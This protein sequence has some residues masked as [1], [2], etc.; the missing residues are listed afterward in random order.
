[1]AGRKARAPR[2]TPEAG[3][4]DV[5]DV[6]VLPTLRAG[7]PQHVPAPLRTFRRLRAA[8]VPRD[9]IV[10]LSCRIPAGRTLEGDNAPLL[11]DGLLPR[12]GRLARRKAPA[13]FVQGERPRGRLPPLRDGPRDAR[14]QT[15]HVRTR[16]G[17]HRGLFPAGRTHPLQ[18]H[19]LRTDCGL[20]VER[21]VQPLPLRGGRFQDHAHHL[22][23]GEQLL[24][25]SRSSR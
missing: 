16:R 7:P 17:R 20:L 9:R 6:G 11:E 4:G 23:P 8:F 5:E 14:G 15:A 22:R 2:G 12:R 3:G 19:A 21:S 24:P 13:V 1:M 10:A 25:R 18:L